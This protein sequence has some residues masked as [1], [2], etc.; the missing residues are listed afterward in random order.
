MLRNRHSSG[1]NRRMITSIR[2]PIRNLGRRANQH[3]KQWTKPATATLLTG[4]LS[5]ITR[6]RADLI[7]ENLMLRQQLIVLNRQVK[8]PLLT[9]GDRI[10]LVLL[11]RCAQFWQQALLLVQPD[12][13]LRWHRD[14]F[15]RY[16]RHKSRP[17]R[18]G[19]RAAPETI[20]LIRK[21]AKE[22]RLWGAERIR[23]ELLKLG[24]R[25]SKRTIQ[26]YMPSVRR[27]P[28]QTWA[29]FLKNHA[30]DIWACDFTVVHDLLFRPLYIFVVIELQTRRIVHAAVTRS[31]TDDWTA[32]QLREATPWGKGAKYL[33]RDRDSR[34]GSLFSKVAKSTGIKVL[35][36]PVRAPKANAICE[37]FIGSLRRGCLNHMLTLHS[38]QLH[39]TV[40]A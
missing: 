13:L 9:D 18:R 22:N 37:R 8:R 27:S 39:R 25:V 34:Y 4:T 1:A 32:Q 36:T 12:T 29:T 5:D 10:R 15:R 6:S 24:V 26:K 40:R 14:L 11:A 21:M 28:S 35:K 31:P 2:S 17:K 20:A 30:G 16:W 23:G 33:I 19:P 7:A 3:L 38:N